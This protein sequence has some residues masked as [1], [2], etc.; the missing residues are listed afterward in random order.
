[1]RGDSYFSRNMKSDIIFFFY[2]V[3][4]MLAIHDVVT[5]PGI[6]KPP[7]QCENLPKISQKQCLDAYCVGN[8]KQFVCEI[9]QCIADDGGEDIAARLAKLK[10]IQNLCS[11][12]TE[13]VVCKKLKLCEAK[14]NDGDVLGYLTCV[15][16]LFSKE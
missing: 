13:E 14:R 11:R 12:N 8:Q 15:I 1:M 7:K 9:L 10:C 4:F 5:E 16:K 6:F 2:L 3:L